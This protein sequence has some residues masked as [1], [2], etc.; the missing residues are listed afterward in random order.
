MTVTSEPNRMTVTSQPNRE[1]PRCPRCRYILLGLTEPRCPECGSPFDPMLIENPTLRSHLLPWERPELGGIV[2]RFRRTLLLVWIHPG[3]LFISLNERKDRR[4]ANAWSLFM[5][6][7]VLSI[8][9][10]GALLILERIAFFHRLLWE[11]GHAW[12][13]YDTVVKTFQVSAS[14]LWLLPAIQVL[15]MTLATFVIAFFLTRVFRKR[16]GILRTADLAAILSPAVL[17][18]ALTWGLAA[19]LDASLKHRFSGVLTPAAIC[20]QPVILLLLVWSC[21]RKLLALN[22]WRAIGVTVVCGLLQCCCAASVGAGL[23]Q[24]PLLA[25]R[26]HSG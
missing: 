3:R 4:I 10:H 5:A 24:L 6:C 11:R 26:H 25:V 14:T 1:Q 12:S 20:A 19:V 7:F 2:R 8:C 9:A 22:R 23:E 15:S 13:A 16:V 21:C 17:L 18:G